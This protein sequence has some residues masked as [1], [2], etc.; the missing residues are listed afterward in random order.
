MVY[1]NIRK[2]KL[3]CGLKEA[4]IWL[5]DLNSAAVFIELD[6]KEVI[7][8]IPSNLSS[9][10]ELGVILNFCKA[11]LRLLPKFIRRQATNVAHLLESSSLSYASS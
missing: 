10:Y 11:S 8:D 1:H 6:C 9:N 3:V 5:G 7:D 4:L 2:R